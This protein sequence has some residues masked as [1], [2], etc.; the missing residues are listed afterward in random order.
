MLEKNPAETA[1]D[2]RRIDE[3]HGQVRLPPLNDQ[4]VEPDDDDIFLEDEDLLLCDHLAR[5]G[6][7]FR[8]GFHERRVVPPVSLRAE[9]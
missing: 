6:Q 4:R 1:T 5:D 3:E 2:H 7:L 9:R 8:D